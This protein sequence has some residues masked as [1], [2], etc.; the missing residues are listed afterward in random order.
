MLFW[1]R[2]FLLM[3]RERTPGLGPRALAA[4]VAV[5]ERTVVA[6]L[7]AAQDGDARTAACALGR[8]APRLFPAGRASWLHASLDAL[9]VLGALPL[10]PRVTSP[11]L[12]CSTL[13]AWGD[14]TTGGHLLHARNFDLPLPTSD[15]PPPLVVAHHPSDGL[16]HV[17]LHHAPAFMPGVTAVNEAGL[18]LGVHQ[19]FTSAVSPTGEGVLSAA[20]R[21]IEHAR[22]L[23]EARDLLAQRPTAVGWSFNVSSAREKDAWSL[24]MDC[25]GLSV[26][27]AAG[28]HLSAVNGFTTTSR[29]AHEYGFSGA[30]TDHNRWRARRLEELAGEFHGELDPGGLALVLG[31][32]GPPGGE[33]PL[34]RSVSAAHNASSWV[35]DQE[36]DC[37][38]LALGGWP[39]NNGDGYAS[40]RLSALME[41]RLDRLGWLPAA[42]GDPG[43][44]PRREALRS[45][46]RGARAWFVDADVEAA[47]YHLAAA[48][49]TDSGEA[50]YAF[51]LGVALLRLGDAA[52]S[53][54][55]LAL[56]ES[57][58][59]PGHR[60]G[61]CALMLGRA[62]DLCG[63]R[64]EARDAYRR[65]LLDVVDDPGLATRA[66]AGTHRPYVRGA[67]KTLVFDHVMADVP[68]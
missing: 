47:R 8:A 51:S 25:H 19:H 1:S 52:S 7:A 40:L 67:L 28:C 65:A 3:V 50:I 34:G 60:R 33:R 43:H 10:A 13:V 2:F 17:S 20:R 22:T 44:A 41:G 46:V 63:R 4:L 48:A 57:L 21:V 11:A 62:L 30:W 56:A 6:T 9:S 49:G 23:E 58:E 38:H 54:R 64:P 32:H 12:G 18:C 35:V 31:D 27:H 42:W 24:E 66:H 61:V 16:R 39:A 45:Y 55:P 37:V 26:R 68:T 53:A 5:L 29:Q 59:D 15:P 36:G 14:A